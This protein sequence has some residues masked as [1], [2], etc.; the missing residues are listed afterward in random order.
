MTPP[1]PLHETSG[2]STCVHCRR[3]FVSPVEWEPIRESGW[4][5]LLRCAECGVSREVTV[6]NAVA[7][8]YD[9]ELARDAK[10]MSHAA[11]RLEMEQMAAE[12]DTFVAALEHGLIE[13]ADF[14]VFP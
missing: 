10:A 9:E 1:H 11:H 2:L 5:M 6:S 4:W 8:R 3:N 7:D 14:S 13:P 12:I